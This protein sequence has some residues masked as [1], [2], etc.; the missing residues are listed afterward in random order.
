MYVR[1]FIYILG[2]ICCVKVLKTGAFYL[3]NIEGYPYLEIERIKN[4]LTSSKDDVQKRGIGTKENYTIKIC[5][6]ALHKIK[7]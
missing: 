1:V 3:T 6:K 4:G 7:R 5:Y 2:Q